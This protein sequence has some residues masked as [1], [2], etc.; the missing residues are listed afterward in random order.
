MGRIT[1]LQAWARGAWEAYAP[2]FLSPW[3]TPPCR[4]VILTTGRTGSELLR[5]LLDSHPGI[6]CDGELL[7]VTPRLPYRYVESAA[8]RAF[9]SATEAYGWKALGAHLTDCLGTGAVR[10]LERLH[11]DGYRFVLLERRDYLQQA[12]SWY[13]VQ[14][15]PFH[16]RKGEDVR[17]VPAVVDPQVLLRATAENE[18]AARSVR[19]MLGGL[20][21]LTLT[22]EDDLLD[23]ADRAKTLDRVCDHLGISRG[24][25]ASDLVRV[26]PR[27]TRDMLS[28]WD[29]VAAAFRGTRWARLVEE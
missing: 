12:M 2:S 13:R 9:P 1:E 20:P 3:R 4:F 14:T 5:Q 11:E 28:N 17:F 8:V 29:E 25:M 22:Y 16:F 19:E 21:R 10:F 7:R 26:T 27:R 24:E 15:E 23:E 18:E 6:V